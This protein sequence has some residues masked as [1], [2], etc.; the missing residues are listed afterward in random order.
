MKTMEVQG[1]QLLESKQ[2]GSPSRKALIPDSVARVVWLVDI[3]FGQYNVLTDD[4]M[5]PPNAATPIGINRV[6]RT[7]TYTMEGTSNGL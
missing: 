5:M 6:R 4:T 3:E 2:H 7:V 1:S